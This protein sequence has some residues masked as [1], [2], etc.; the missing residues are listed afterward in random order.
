MDAGSPFRFKIATEPWEFAQIHRLNYKTFVE[1]IPQHAANRLRTRVDKFHHE[2]TYVICL[3]GDRVVG[4]VAVRSGHPFSLDEKLEDL[5]SYLPPGRS[6]CELRLLSIERDY[7]RGVLFHGLLRESVLHCTAQGYDLVV[8]SGALSQQKLYER[9]GFVPFG[10]VVGTPSARYQPRFVTSERFL[11][12]AGKFLPDLT[13]DSAASNPVNLLPGP[14]EIRPEVRKAFQEAPIS[15]RSDIFMRDFHQ[16]KRLLCEPLGSGRVEIFSGS[17][18]LANDVIAGQLSLIPGRGGQGLILSNGEFGE[19]LILHATR[20]RLPF[21]TFRLEWGDTFDRA[22]APAS[23]G[24]GFKH[25][26]VVGRSLR[27]LDR[28]PERHRG[29]EGDLCGKRHPPLYG[30]HQLDRHGPHRPGRRVPRIR[31]ERKRNRRVP[32]VVAGVL[33]PQGPSGPV[34]ASGVSGPRPLQRKRRGAVHDFLE[35][36]LCLA[37]GREAASP[38]KAFR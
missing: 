13:G 31:G 3:L 22:P 29:V 5:D 6:V 18:T 20:F 38:K 35:S 15:H 12:K 1:E 28:R 32:G 14:V 19:R 11:E 16:T 24:P 10:P 21:E 30:L 7:R 8:I 9:L 26:V 37:L 34:R 27:N 25:P 36:S 23:P 2:N 17:G 33:S 4:M